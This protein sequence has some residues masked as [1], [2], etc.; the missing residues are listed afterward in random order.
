M[1]I[2][3]LILLVFSAVPIPLTRQLAPASQAKHRNVAPARHTTPV[4][5]GSMAA[6][7]N[8]S[9]LP[10][11]AILAGTSQ[12]WATADGWTTAKSYP[13]RLSERLHTPFADQRKKGTDGGHGLTI[14]PYFCDQTTN[15][16]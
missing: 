5:S 8:P 14:W 15:T 13:S 16:C 4:S 9:V 1:L 10:G 12:A 2:L 6:A 3:L 11:M 7:I